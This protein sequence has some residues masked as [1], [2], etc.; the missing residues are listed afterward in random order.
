MKTSGTHVKPHDFLLRPRQRRAF[1]VKLTEKRTMVDMPSIIDAPQPFLLSLNPL[2][3][4]LK[5]S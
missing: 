5:S 2:L 4:G 3:I 1:Q